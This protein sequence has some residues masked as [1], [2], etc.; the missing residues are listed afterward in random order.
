MERF[1][2]L[3]GKKLGH[4]YSVPIH[5]YM[6]NSNYSLFELEKDELASF[7]HRDDLGGINITIPYK[8]DVMPF[9]DC[10]SEEALKIGSVN[11]IVQRNGKLFGYN[12]DKY[13]FCLMIK[14]AGID[15]NG[16]KVLVLG[17][18]GASRTACYCAKELGASK[19]VVISRSGENNYGNLHKHRDAQIIVNT[20][21]VG[22][23]PDNASSPLSL[24]DFPNCT[25][26]ADVIYNPLRTALM[27]EAESLNIK[28]AGGLL[29]LTAQ[30][31][32]AEELFFDTAIDDSVCLNCASELLRNSQNIVLIGM[33]GSGKS[34]VGNALA[35]LTGREAIETDALIE[36]QSGKSIPEI[37]R[38]NG[39]AV[40]RRIEAEVIA[41]A[42]KQSGKIIM[43][44][45]GAVTTPANYLPLHQNGRIYEVMRDIDSLATDGR[46]LS[47]DIDTL[48][49][50]YKTRRPMY[51]AFRDAFVE[52]SGTPLDTA[53][54][55]WSDFNENTCY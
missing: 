1:Y 24:K 8:I 54:M 18:G 48:K 12:T 51:D 5:K 46:P 40:F 21:P 9:C 25:G 36:E 42:A 6:G 27:A 34:A 41:N 43:T 3:I 23:Y 55:I 37:F 31:K 32:Q 10:I 4:S 52:N 17:S 50:M 53:K 15:M 22:M 20:T 19:V 2:G 28:T 7:L 13:G 30:A 14:H 11:T 29:M 16:K 44:G 38:D 47:K 33:P 39:E 45:G 49:E 26:V 35:L